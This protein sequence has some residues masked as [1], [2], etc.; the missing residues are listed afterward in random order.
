[1]LQ[2]K[3]SGRVPFSSEEV[4]PVILLRPLNDGMIPTH[5]MKSNLLYLKPSDLKSVSSEN[6]CKATFRTMF[7][8]I[9]GYC[10]L[11]KMTHEINNRVLQIT[12]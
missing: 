12:L 3:S 1:M 11:T 8:Q 4:G 9:S 10:D 6:T 5:T 7:D 2:P